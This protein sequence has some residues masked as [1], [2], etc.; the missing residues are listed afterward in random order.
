MQDLE[1]APRDI[2]AVVSDAL[3]VS[4]NFHRCRDE[5]KI[6]RDGLLERE[7]L[8]TDIIDFEFKLI[9][10]VVFIDYT[11]GKRRLTFDESSRCVCYCGFCFV[12]DQEQLFIQRTE[13]TLV[14]FICM[15]AVRHRR[16]SK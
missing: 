6:R 3:D 2:H 4:N 7:D 5:T 8:E 16:R 12:A 15:C 1:S 10:L 11:L 13:L 9:Q 14:V